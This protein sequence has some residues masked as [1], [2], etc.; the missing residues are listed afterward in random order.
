MTGSTL[1]CSTMRMLAFILAESLVS[2]SV[3]LKHKNSQ[4]SIFFI[5]ETIPPTEVV[6]DFKNL[7]MMNRR[8]ELSGL[9]LDE[10]Q[11]FIMSHLN[12]ETITNC[13]KDP[14]RVLPNRRQ[15]YN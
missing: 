14:G 11:G 7:Y 13:H 5:H 10:S 8:C 6:S 1:T 12:K 15:R 9:L 4:V 3:K 2:T